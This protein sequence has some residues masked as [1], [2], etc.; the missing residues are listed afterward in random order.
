MSML[1]FAFC[2]LIVLSACTPETT[3]WESEWL[4]PLAKS[5]LTLQ[6]LTGDTL[7]KAN[8]SDQLVLR[9]RG[10]VLDLALDTL[11]KLDAI[12]S[13][14]TFAWNFGQIMIPPNVAIPLDPIEI[15]FN[16]PDAEV[17]YALLKSGSADITFKSKIPRKVRFTYSIPLATK[18]GQPLRFEDEL[19]AWDGGPNPQTFTRSF[20]L[21]GYA[22]DLR[23]QELTSSNRI[24]ISVVPTI[25]AGEDS[26]L[27]T[28]NMELFSVENELKG[29]E[30]SF[31]K[32][33]LATHELDIQLDTLNLDLLKNVQAGILDLE[34]AQLQLSLINTLGAELRIR[35]AKLSATNSRTGESLNLQH[36]LVGSTVFLDRATEG[37]A[38]AVPTPSRADWYINDQNSNLVPWLELLPDQLI[39][40]LGI[41][42]NPLGNTAGLQDFIYPAYLPQ[43]RVDAEVP[44]KF[45]LQDLK[46]QDTIDADLAQI[47]EL[48]HLVE[49]EIRLRALNQFPM[50][51]TLHLIALDANTHILDTL[52]LNQR[53]DAAALNANLK[54]D[55]SRESILSSVLGPSQVQALKQTTRF[56]IQAEVS[57][58]PPG[59]RLWMYQDYGLDIQVIVQALIQSQAAQNE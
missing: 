39:F 14:D 1:R 59:N 5:R 50:E 6:Q 28:Q 38:N 31:L 48:N 55:Q 27:L 17:V 53:I 7:L 11:A 9:Y 15:R 54:V 36:S 44:I 8:E 13:A 18:N 10:D 30:A 41:T 19:P 24:H 51:M 3:Q 47:Q 45:S 22:L 12:A 33:A 26:L 49:G 2:W 25:A 23:G 16:I 40:D 29:L 35:P 32:G 4:A 57:T 56:L 46:L 43:L 58:L 52:M 21:G 20:P 37:V 42:V 34:S